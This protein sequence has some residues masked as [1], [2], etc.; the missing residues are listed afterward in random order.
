MFGLSFSE[1]IIIGIVAL[2]VFG[3]EKL[4][5]VFSKMGKLTGELKKTSDGLRREFYN[6]AYP[7]MEESKIQGKEISLKTES[8]PSTEKKNDSKTD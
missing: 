6:S 8:N 2:I 4:P 3:P 5:E 7:P 1:L